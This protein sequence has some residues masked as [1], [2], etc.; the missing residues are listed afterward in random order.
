VLKQVRLLLRCCV[1]LLSRYVVVAFCQRRVY[2]DNTDSA[3][4]RV[5]LPSQ[6][7]SWP[8]SQCTQRATRSAQS[9][10]AYYDLTLPYLFIIC[11]L[12]Y[13][14]ILHFTICTLQL[15]YAIQTSALRYCRVYDD[16]NDSA[17]LRAQL[18]EGQ[19]R[20]STTLV[21]L[22]KNAAVSEYQ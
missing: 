17:Q 9:L 1:T 20:P 19:L 3:Q 18:S 16:N 8:R 14:I 2:D 11:T 15:L 5:L 6:A 10:C 7:A 13:S 21:M 12:R 4:W 22:G